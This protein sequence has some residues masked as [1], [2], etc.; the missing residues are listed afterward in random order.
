MK[1]YNVEFKCIQGE[2]SGEVK[3]LGR[4]LDYL[5]PRGEA[6]AYFKNHPSLYILGYIYETTGLMLER[7]ENGKVEGEW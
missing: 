2:C 6:R 7:S 4:W 1:K 5:Y 3:T